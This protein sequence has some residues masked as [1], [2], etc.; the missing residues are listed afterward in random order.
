MGTVHR[1]VSWLVKGRQQQV[2]WRTEA[3]LE[4]VGRALGAAERQ[5]VQSW[6]QGRGA[7]AEGGKGGRLRVALHRSGVEE[8]RVCKL[9]L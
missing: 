1:E 7:P 9:L 3:V 8:V 4:A 2:W 6:L 5:Q